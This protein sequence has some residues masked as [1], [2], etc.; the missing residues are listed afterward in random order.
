MGIEITDDE[1]KRV[2]IKGIAERNKMTVEQFAQQH[3]RVRRR[4]LRPCAIEI[5]GAI[6]MARGGAASAARCR[7]PSTS[8]TSS[9]CSESANEAGEDTIELQ[10]QRITLSTPAPDGSD[11]HGQALCRGRAA[12]AQVR[13]L[14]EHA[15]PGQG[16]QRGQVRRLE[17]HQAQHRCPS[18]RARMLLSAKD[19]DMLPP[20]TA[21][22]GV[23][24]YAVCARRPIKADEKTREKAMEELAAKE[25]E[26]LAKRYLRDLRQDAHIEYR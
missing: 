21:A 3:Q 15:R 2:M 11:R 25:F 12:A 6:C 22:A 24:I 26:A 10:V 19:G 13:R 1:V 18:P 5:E 9:G 16:G 23:E 4:H 8:A 14:Q 7:S 20:A 17:V